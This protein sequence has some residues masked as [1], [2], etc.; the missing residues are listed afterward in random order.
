M[1]K[2]PS[3]K[4]KLGAERGKKLHNLVEHFLSTKPTSENET[5]EDFLLA[6]DLWEHD[7]RHGLRSA[8]T[9]PELVELR[10]LAHEP[11][12]QVDILVEQGF[13]LTPVYLGYI[14]LIVLDRRNGELNVTIHDH[15]FMANK[16]SVMTEEEARK[17]YQTLIYA[18][19]LISYFPIKSIGFSYDYYG[20][21]YKWKEKCNF[22][23][24]DY[25]INA[26]WS[27]VLS[28]THK[29]LNNY[30]I[31]SGRNTIPNYLSCGMY[32]GCDYLHICFGE[33]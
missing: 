14:D 26:R 24:T 28:D 30:L 32:G 4:P 18:K 5:F 3:Q 27:S 17:D 6:N 33:S 19:S 15:K 22:M 25:D 1:G 29:V 20:T 16:R 31:G 9:N 23:L 12:S 11:N 2:V 7:L 21:K 10:N 13:T 8:N